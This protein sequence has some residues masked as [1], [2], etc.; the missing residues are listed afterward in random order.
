[1][2]LLLLAAAFV[3][4]IT[5]VPAD[6]SAQQR[7]RPG[8]DRDRGQG[9]GADKDEQDRERRERSRREWQPTTRLPGERNAGPCPFGKVLY[10]A[11]RYVEFAEA[12]EAAGAVSWSGEIQSLSAE[13]RYREDEP[14]VIDVDVNFSFGK[15]PQAQGEAK[16]YRWWVAVTERNK[17]V[18]AKEYF[19]TDARFNGADRVAVTERLGG[20]VIPRASQTVS[21]AQFEVLV[22]FDV[23]PQMATFNREG[24][25]FRVDAGQAQARTQ[26]Q[27]PG[28]TTTR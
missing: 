7:Q 5:A 27:T 3:A 17:N 4:A 2:R 18:L 25:R 19:A 28:Q 11:G 9:G 10:D 23:T 14:I 6:S 22:G 26:T 13:C 1:M 16:S 8:Q 21:G 20:I 15:G 12:R 24:K